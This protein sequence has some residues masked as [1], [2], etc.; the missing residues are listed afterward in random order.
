MAYNVKTTEALQEAYDAVYVKKPVHHQDPHY[1]WVADVLKLRPGRSLLDVACGPGWMLFEAARRGLKAEGMDLS[2]NA[3]A[4][5]RRH[6]PSARVEVGD[7]EHL[8]W[9][10][11]AFDYV[12]CLGSLEHYL[13]PVEG[14]NEISRVLK[15]GGTAFVMLPNK[16]YL[17]HML[18]EIRTGRGP[19]EQE[20]FERLLT[21]QEW[22][23]LIAQSRLEIVRVVRQNEIKPLFWPGSRK[24]RSLNKVATSWLYRLFCPL[25]FS[26]HFAFICRKRA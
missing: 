23:E 1:R 17:K 12:T 5:A 26:Y 6:A 18:Q 4:L 3:V 25:D 24:I 19:D 14:L 13:H 8:S 16:Y 20:G 22:G 11:N 21:R 9:P 15:P 10:D 7:G 2:P